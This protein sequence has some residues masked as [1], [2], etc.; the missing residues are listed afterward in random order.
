MYFY[1]IMNWYIYLVLNHSHTTLVKRRG[2]SFGMEYVLWNNLYIFKAW[3]TFPYMTNQHW[4]WRVNPLV[5]QV[6]QFYFLPPHVSMV[7]INSI[8]ITTQCA[9][10]DLYNSTH[11]KTL[12]LHLKPKNSWW[13]HQMETICAGNPGEFLAQRPVT[14]SFDVFWFFDLRLNKRLSKQS[15]GWWFETLS[16]P[17]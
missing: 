3:R 14:R 13:R 6:R 16:R 2:I 12:V 1:W 10:R 5:R 11:I 4:L 9:R 15:R 17:L 7:T 8:F